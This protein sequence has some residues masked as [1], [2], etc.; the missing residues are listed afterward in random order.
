MR[1]PGGAYRKLPSFPRRSL[2]P[3][4]LALYGHR[5][6][7]VTSS[8]LRFIMMIKSSPSIVRTT[9][10]T[11]H[12]MVPVPRSVHHG[13]SSPSS[14]TTAF[15]LVYTVLEQPPCF[16]TVG[17]SYPIGCDEYSYRIGGCSTGSDGQRHRR[18]PTLSAELPHRSWGSGLVGFDRGGHHRAPHRPPARPDR[19]SRR[20]FRARRFQPR[21]P[22]SPHL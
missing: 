15:H 21:P 9:F 17:V 5:S 3:L 18:M 8:S 13:S 4:S 11:C 7:T 19:R 16:S 2:S 6:P 10:P 12:P 22:R 20:L 14:I 1:D